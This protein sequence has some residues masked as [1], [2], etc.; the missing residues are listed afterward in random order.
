MAIWA[1][2]ATIFKFLAFKFKALRRWSLIH[3]SIISNTL[4]LLSSF[5]I[6]TKLIKILRSCH[7]SFYKLLI[8]SLHLQ[9]IFHFLYL[10]LLIFL[11]L[12]SDCPIKMRFYI[13]L[14]ISKLINNLLIKLTITKWVK[15]I[16][17]ILLVIFWL[18]FYLILTWCVCSGVHIY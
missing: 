1:Y 3:T 9:F 10:I 16:I 5:C 6:M 7:N 14:D 12:F 2:W 13:I 4:W 8:I 17:A 15:L 11:I 18:F